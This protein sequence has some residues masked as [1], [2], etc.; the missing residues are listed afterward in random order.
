MITTQDVFIYACA[1]HA[2]QFRHNGITPYIS[3]PAAVAAK[4]VSWNILDFNMLA[5]A[6]L[7]DVLEDT[8][9][10]EAELEDKFGPK[11]TS[12]VDA[13]TYKGPREGKQV[14]INSL[15]HAPLNVRILKAAD[16]LCNVQ[17]FINDGKPL[18]ALEYLHAA[19][20]IFDTLQDNEVI[21]KEYIDMNIRLNGAF[22]KESTPWVVGPD[23]V[24]KAVLEDIAKGNKS[25]FLDRSI[26]HQLRNTE[27]L[28]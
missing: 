11:I 9:A 10:T 27:V 18:E 16:R 13:V 26:E 1:R 25:L 14:H 7:H 5:A 4:L 28:K 21:I 6:W 12:L 24:K 2:G 15:A 19:D 17:D 20:A 23:W 22:T 8:S 3:H